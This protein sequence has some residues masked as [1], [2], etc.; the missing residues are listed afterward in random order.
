MNRRQ[1]CCQSVAADAYVV[2]MNAIAQAVG[3]ASSGTS[4]LPDDAYALWS[5]LIPVLQPQPGRGYM[6]AQRTAAPDALPYLQTGPPLTGI[7]KA[8]RTAAQQ[9]SPYETFVPLEAQ[10]S[11]AEALAQAAQRQRKLPSSSDVS[12]WSNAIA[13]SRRNKLRR[14]SISLH[15]LPWLVGDLI[16]KLPASTRIGMSFLR[17]AFPTLTTHVALHSFGRA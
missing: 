11:F 15:T 6:I 17:S 4:G 9:H 14:I 10:A 13:C 1:F 2:G 3:T 5:L 8:R 16:P 7:E 12:R